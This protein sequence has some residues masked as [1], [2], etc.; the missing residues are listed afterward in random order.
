MASPLRGEIWYAD[1]N[2]PR[3]HE[4]A[5]RRPVLVVSTNQF[6]EGPAD[7][8]VILPLTSKD[9]G[10]PWRVAIPAQEAGLRSDS[11][12][13]CE[14]IRCIAK[15]RFTKR[16][17]EVTPEVLHEVDERMRILLEL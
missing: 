2:P 15:E 9:K 16:S 12:I 5:G 7:L 1:L 4:Q 10:I 17:G 14:A 8:V 11:F 3:G 13:M 6:N